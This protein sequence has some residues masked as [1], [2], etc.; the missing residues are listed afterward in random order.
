MCVRKKREAFTLQE[1]V[2]VTMI[3][4]IIIGAA[5]PAYRNIA[6]QSRASAIRATLDEVRTALQAYRQNERLL[7][8]AP[9]G[10][11]RIEAVRDMN[12]WGGVC[13]SVGSCVSDHIFRDC[14]MPDNPFSSTGGCYPD[15]VQSCTAPECVRGYCVSWYGWYYNR[16]S[17]DFWAC[18]NV[19]GENNW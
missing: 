8:H 11:P 16:N 13:G 17:G 15:V 4:A 9:A 1:V 7:M 10:Y 6:Q 3:L 5:I 19:M 18:S 14:D 2:L 12:D